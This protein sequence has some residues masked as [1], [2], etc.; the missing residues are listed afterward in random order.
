MDTGPVHAGFDALDSA[1]ERAVA[2]S[3]RNIGK[4]HTGRQRRAL[5]VFS[6]LIVHNMA[7]I[8]L[9][10]KFFDDEE[11]G[12]LDH[13]S[14][15]SLA[16]SSL[17]AA[18]MTMYISEPS[19]NLTRWDFRR[20]LLFLHDTNNRSRFLKPL[21]KDGVEFGFFENADAVRD[22]IRSKL[23]KLGAELLYSQEKIAD[24]QRGFHIF[25]DGVRGAV[26]EA[27]WDVDEFE[28]NQSYLS[29]YVHSHPVSFI[30]LDEH[31]VTFE[32]ASQFQ[33]DFCHY[34]LEMTAGYLASVADRMDAFSLP[35]EGDPNGHLE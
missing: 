33:V 12:L 31:Q 15:A 9:T 13:F 16:R 25:V 5:A 26:R 7:M 14:L 29:A 34:L 32:G 2:I 1:S 17:D 3:E 28:F 19:L 27:G 30:R 35:G 6:K 24:Y 8:L 11:R 20:Q 21:R 4:T 10:K 23:G 22:G 18:L